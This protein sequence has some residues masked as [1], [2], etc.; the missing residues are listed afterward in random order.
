MKHPYIKACLFLAMAISQSGVA[1]AGSPLFNAS[2]SGALLTVTT[3]IPGRVYPQAGIRVNTPGYTA[4][5]DAG[6]AHRLVG[7]TC[8]PLSNG[9]CQF[10]VSNTNPVELVIYSTAATGLTT[11]IPAPTVPISITLCLNAR[12]PLSCQTQIFNYTDSI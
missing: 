12:G 11:S 5:T 2:M 4:V 8:S 7:N 10:A 1:N 6:F 9:F 3:N